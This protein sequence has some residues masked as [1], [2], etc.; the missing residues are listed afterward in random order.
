[1]TIVQSVRWKRRFFELPNPLRR[2]KV[3]VAAYFDAC[4]AVRAAPL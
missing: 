4:C 1:M 2:P 3:S